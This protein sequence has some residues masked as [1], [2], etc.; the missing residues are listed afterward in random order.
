M[1]RRRNPGVYWIGVEPNAEAAEAARENGRCDLVKPHTVET[2]LDIWGND[3]L[4]EW[5]GKDPDDPSCD[6]FQECDGETADV[7]ICADV[8]EHMLDPWTQLKRLVRHVAPGGVVLASIP[9]IGH[10]TIIKGLLGGGWSYQDDGLL[11]RTHLRFF[12]LKTVKELFAQAGLHVVE[13]QG[14][15]LCNEGFA[16]WA[17]EVGPRVSS[18]AEKKVYQYLVRAIK[19]PVD[20]FGVPFTEDGYKVTSDAVEKAV[21]V[22]KM[23]IHALS[24]QCQENGTVCIRPRI[25][26]P[27]A[28][29]A[30]IP[31]V[32]ISTGPVGPDPRSNHIL[33]QQRLFTFD[34]EVQ[35]KLLADG[36]ILVAEWDDNP[37]TFPRQAAQDFMALRAV[38]A[39]QAS[40]EKLAEVVRQWN[41]NVVVFENQMKELPPWKERK[42]DRLVTIFFGA[43]NREHDWKPIMPAINRVIATHGENLCFCVIHDKEFFN[44][45]ACPAAHKEFQPFVPYDQYMLLLRSCD[46]ALLPLE[47]GETNECKSDIKFLECAANGVT[48]LASETV[49]AKVLDA[50]FA[51]YTYRDP[52]TFEASLITLLGDPKLR[53]AFARDAY[54]YVRDRRLLGQHYRKQYAWYQSLLADRERL[55][56]ELLERV[57]SLKGGAW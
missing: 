32:T 31:G 53:Q 55:H 40:T 23:H 56:A 6:V 19:P 24:E 50:L 47:P 49:Y 26:E 42:P 45:L 17:E 29:L 36:L 16:E 18:G 3:H 27:L 33:I 44:A 20:S 35:R 5:K 52:M 51:G 1:Y 34:L 41:P 7:L 54:A 21:I 22:P 11:D 10:W 8:L 30:T 13:I 25:D 38:H 2:A 37:R 46:I 57:P 4:Y 48:V 28:A 9:N 12:V 43:L 15:L 39:V 14:R